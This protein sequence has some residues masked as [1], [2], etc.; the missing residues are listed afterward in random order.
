MSY[1]VMS[2]EVMSF[3]LII[4][5]FKLRVRMDMNEFLLSI[6]HHLISNIN[7]YINLNFFPG[8]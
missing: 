1:E 6:I 3:G 7:N 2:Y 5:N 4:T 8:K